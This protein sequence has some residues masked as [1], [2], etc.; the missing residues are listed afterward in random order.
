MD[1]N[2]SYRPWQ[3]EA[4]EAVFEALAASLNNAFG[5]SVCA[6][7][8]GAELVIQYGGTTAWIGLNGALTGAASTGSFEAF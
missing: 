1:E 7:V 5:E 2:H 3:A 6:R 4:D 8:E